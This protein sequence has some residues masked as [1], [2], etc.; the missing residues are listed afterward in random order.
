MMTFENFSR[1]I[2]IWQGLLDGDGIQSPFGTFQFLERREELLA[3]KFSAS[4]LEGNPSGVL[5]VMQAVVTHL[6]RASHER[7]TQHRA[8]GKSDFEARNE[9]QFFLGRDLSLAF[10]EATVLQRFLNHIGE[11]EIYEFR[12]KAVLNDLAYLFGL[13]CLI[14]NAAH[15]VK[16]GVVGPAA[17]GNFMAWLHPEFVRTCDRLKPNSVGLADVLA[18]T[19]FVLNSALGHSSGDIY[20]QLQKS[21]FQVPGGFSK[22]EYWPEVTENFRKSKL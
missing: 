16:F 3:K 2:G 9:S 17:A 22:A 5:T 15:L 7:V 11:D 8:A 21:F 4:D 13:D 6:V 1:L 20:K 14:K 18:P 12:E 19:D 10:V